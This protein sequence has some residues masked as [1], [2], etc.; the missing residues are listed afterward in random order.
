MNRFFTFLAIA[1]VGAFLAF[2]TVEVV[3]CC[4]SEV[5]D[6]TFEK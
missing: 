4:E 3:A 2:Y 1:V 5:A 6:Q